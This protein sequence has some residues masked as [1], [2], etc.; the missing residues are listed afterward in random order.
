MKGFTMVLM[1]IQLTVT[2]WGKNQGFMLI[3]LLNAGNMIGC[4]GEPIGI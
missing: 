4:G 1:K 2:W 3:R